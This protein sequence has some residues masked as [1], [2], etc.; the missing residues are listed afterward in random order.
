[1]RLKQTQRA[2]QVLRSANQALEKAEQEQQLVDEVCRI[3][4][5][6]GGYRFAWVGYAQDDAQKHVR[7]V[8][9]AGHHPDYLNEIKISWGDEETGNGPAGIAIKTATA[10]VVRHIDDTPHFT[11]W[12]EKAKKYGYKSVIALPLGWRGKT[13]G[14]MAILSEEPDAFDEGE[15]GLL[16][17]LAASLSYGINALRASEQ[18]DRAEKAL[19]TER[20][21]QEVLHRILSLSLE[22]NSLETKLNRVLEVLFDIP[23]LTLERKGSVFLVDEGSRSL[24]LVAKQHLSP[25]LVDKCER[26]PFGHC[27]CGRAAQSGELLFHNHL[28]A[29]HDTRFQGMQDHGHY[30]QPIRSAKGVIGVLNL[31]VAA[32]HQPTPEEAPFLNAVADTL[33]SLIERQQAEMAQQ[34]L[35]TLLEATPDLVTITDTRGNCLYCNDGAWNMFNREQKDKHCE[36]NIICHYPA[37]VARRM[38]DEIYPDAIAAGIWEGE[39]TINRPDGSPLPVSQLVIAHRDEHGE[40]S[41]L[42]TI[43]RDITDR[44]R[45]ETAAQSAALREKNFANSVINNLPGIF[46][47]VD[48]EGKLLRWNSNLEQSL[49]YSG[50]QLHGM[51]LRALV[52]EEDVAKMQQSCR[53]II[54]YGTASLEVGLATRAGETIPFFINGIRIENSDGGTAIVGI[55]I[56]ISYRLKLEQELRNRA[57]T[58]TLTGAYNRL[59]MEEELE[60]EIR[61]STRYKTPFAIAMFDID[62]FKQV[63]DNHGHDIGDEVLKQIVGITRQQLREVDLLARWGGEEFMIIASSTTLDDIHKLAERVRHAIAAV[64]L[65]PV[66]QITVSFGVGEYRPGEQQKDLLKRVDDMLYQAKKSGR[67]RVHI[68]L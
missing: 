12:Q 19:R 37:D 31:Y 20:D 58:D 64:P 35:I 15:S 1:M 30:C 17:E 68:A 25:V 48:Q 47:L 41:Y 61:K 29:A 45:A 57:T 27:L 5:D 53:E 13:F 8:A 18:R 63:N 50:D 44:K 43:A 3:A 7:F 67:N 24:R 21:T 42:S 34:R 32:G 51:S 2:L 46:Y 4:V 40:V 54:D 6:V 16:Q 23:W 66:G 11:P 55:G 36:Q 22:K 10:N 62:H 28:D 56:D 39:L 38:R 9:C 14:C 60:Q 26:V 65:E 33:A 52:A 49:A 59:R